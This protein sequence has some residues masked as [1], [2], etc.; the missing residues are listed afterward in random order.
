MKIQESLLNA[1][2]DAYTSLRKNIDHKNIT[3]TDLVTTLDII[4]LKC[5][6]DVDVSNIEKIIDKERIGVKNLLTALG[7]QKADFMKIRDVSLAVVKICESIVA[8]I[9]LICEQKVD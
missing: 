6:P 1:D 4:K 3:L 2:L 5:P 8:K 9:D 7:Y